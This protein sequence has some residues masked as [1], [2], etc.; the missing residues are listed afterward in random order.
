MGTRLSKRGKI[1]N[2]EY[3]ELQ[4]HA[5]FATWFLLELECIHEP[6]G[7]VLKLILSALLLISIAAVVG[8]DRFLIVHVTD[9]LY[10]AFLT[11]HT[12]LI[13]ENS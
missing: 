5:L 7:T 9:L 3:Q 2:S 10:F 6:L 8:L 13:I 11:L 12:I 1:E 4:F